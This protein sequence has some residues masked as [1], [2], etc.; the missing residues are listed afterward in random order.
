MFETERYRGGVG[1]GL[2]IGVVLAVFWA[3]VVVAV[4]LGRFLPASVSKFRS[5]WSL[6]LPAGLLLLIV[7]AWYYYK[8]HGFTET[9]KGIVIGAAIVF[10]LSAGCFALMFSSK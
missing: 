10:L 8:A 4:P 3:F 1:C 7:P 9:A 2:G 5:S 6:L